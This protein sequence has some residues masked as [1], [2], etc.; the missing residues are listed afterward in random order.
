MSGLSLTA[1]F[2]FLI[3]MDSS[4][5][6]TANNSTVTIKVGDLLGSNADVLV[7]SGSI[8]VPMIGGFPEVVRTR[9]GSCLVADASK[10]SDAKL[11][12]VVV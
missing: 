4:K 10:H 7:I 6:Y 5:T 9:G 1:I 3:E 8:G 2:I 12:D 11:G